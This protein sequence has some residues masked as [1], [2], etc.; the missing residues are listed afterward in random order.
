MVRYIVV[1]A[2]FMNACGSSSSS[3]SSE[4]KSNVVVENYSMS[5]HIQDPDEVDP[6]SI[7]TPVPSYCSVSF[8][9]PFSCEKTDL[10]V[11]YDKK[12]ITYTFSLSGLSITSE[13]QY[14]VKFENPTEDENGEVARA[15][16]NLT[17]TCVQ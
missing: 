10:V 5:C 16:F 6:D 14:S 9:A 15:D 11:T 13:S 17:A 8:T 4:S 12:G 3:S 1:L 2:I 7:V